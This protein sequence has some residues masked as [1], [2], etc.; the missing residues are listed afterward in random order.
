MQWARGGVPS[1]RRTLQQICYLIQQRGTLSPPS[2]K[3]LI[4]R[5]RRR[6]GWWEGV[7]PPGSE[8]SLHV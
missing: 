8:A 6:V 1:P 7:A 3:K 2:K 5:E 4:Q